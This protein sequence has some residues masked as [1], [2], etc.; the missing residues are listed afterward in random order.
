MTRVNCTWRTVPGQSGTGCTIK[1]VH[2]L[3][4]KTL[5]WPLDSRAHAVG[6]ALAVHCHA[7]C[8]QLACRWTRLRGRMPDDIRSRRERF[9]A[10]QKRQVAVFSDCVGVVLEPPAARITPASSFVWQPQKMPAQRA[11][12]VHRRSL[13]PAPPVAQTPSS[14]N[15]RTQ[16]QFARPWSSSSCPS[17]SVLTRKAT[18]AT[19]P[20]PMNTNDLTPDLVDQRER[21]RIAVNRDSNRATAP[22][23]R[24][25]QAR[26]ALSDEMHSLRSQPHRPAT[27]GALTRSLSMRPKF[28][29]VPVDKW[30]RRSRHDLFRVPVRYMVHTPMDAKAHAKPHQEAFVW[31][32]SQVTTPPRSP[33]HSPLRSPPRSPPRSPRQVSPHKGLARSPRQVSPHKGLASFA[34][35]AEDRWRQGTIQSVRDAKVDGKLR[36]MPSATRHWLPEAARLETRRHDQTHAWSSQSFGSWG[37]LNPNRAPLT[38][39]LP[40]AQRRSPEPA[41]RDE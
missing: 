27:G 35:A 14:Q 16:L 2:E 18:V 38:K 7:R 36:R 37:P 17:L 13:P 23:H 32:E 8:C 9:A 34:M 1:Y 11:T 29:A 3:C 4:Y 26:M 39:P 15:S 20:L 41:D 22:W 10:A 28:D 19:V 31:G 21:S 6:G 30:L 5:P 12:S 33:S 25:A 40:R 24:D